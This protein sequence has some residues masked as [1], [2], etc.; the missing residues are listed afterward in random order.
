MN[1]TSAEF[2]TSVAN[3]ADILETGMPEFAFV[4]RSNVG[5]SST[6]NGLLQKK[7][8]AKTSAMPGLTK[9]I[10]YFV[11]N[12]NFV[13]VD[14]P[15]YGYAKTSKV[16][17]GTWSSLIGDYL[18]S[19]KDLKMVLFLLDIRREPSELDKIMLDFMIANDLPFTII[20]TKADKLSTMAQKQSIKNIAEKF[21]VREEMIFVYSSRT[22]QGR[23]AIL[24][25]IDGIINF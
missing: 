21:G 20:A 24:Q 5:K 15:G 10:N 16:H 12:K 1:I 8:L 11:V 2:L 3:R 22:S 25:Y 17:Q 19:S 18:L 7:G 13:F 23:E 14:L 6:I 4:G 9:L